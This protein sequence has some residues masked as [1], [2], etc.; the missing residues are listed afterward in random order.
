[1][2]LPIP[3]VPLHPGTMI[4]RGVA[5]FP[6][7]YGAVFRIVTPAEALA[8]PGPAVLL[9]NGQQLG[10][11]TER[12]TELL[13]RPGLRAGLARHFSL[14]IDASGEGFPV[15]PERL[16]QWHAALEA[17]G[18]APGRA[19]YLTHN[20]CVPA[21]IRAWQRESGRKAGVR[22]LLH[23]H[24]LHLQALWVRDRVASPAERQRR[25]DALPEVPEQA[26]GKARF[27]CLNNKPHAHRMVIAG[28]ILGGPLAARTLLSFGSATEHVAQWDMAP[29][30]AQARQVLPRFGP[31]LDV[32]G[33][34]LSELP[35]TI[36]GDGG[37]HVVFGMPAALYGAAS[38]SLVAETNFSHPGVERFTEKSVKALAAG[39]PAII[40][41]SPRTLRLLRGVGFATFDPYIDEAYD[42]IA[43][44]QDRLMAVLSE[45]ERIAGLP[46]AAFAALLRRCLPAI[47]HNMRHAAETL[48]ALMQWRLEELGRAL[49]WMADPSSN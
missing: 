19:A 14:A 44:P 47:E 1:M 21:A 45:A 32:F 13:A 22:V 42:D 33:A 8:D 24:F 9:I 40:A 23:H 18:I 38:M 16:V 28:R 6:R 25:I 39:H 2:R 5:R 46:D 7:D 48:P 12:L 17:H 4:A 35:L 27:L 3:L 15:A 11:V 37:G 34:R 20:E 10:T 26:A 41:S 36:P 31:D 30:L 43:D 49:A 29:F